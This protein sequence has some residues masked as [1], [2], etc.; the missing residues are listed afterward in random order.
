ML[1]YCRISILGFLV[2]LPLVS[3]QTRPKS[4]PPKN[5]PLQN[6]LHG[7]ARKN[8]LIYVRTPS[9]IYFDPNDRLVDVTDTLEILSFD[10]AT[11]GWT[12]PLKQVHPEFLMRENLLQFC[13]DGQKRFL[14]SSKLVR[15]D[16]MVVQNYRDFGSSDCRG[17]Y[18]Y[19]VL[20]NDEVVMTFHLS[21]M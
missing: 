3:C 1:D 14:T 20:F 13:M 6:D 19:E 16:A 21:V 2:T 8:M 7:D 15:T 4:D 10:G 5:V 11:F 18:L 9:V 17:T 12:I